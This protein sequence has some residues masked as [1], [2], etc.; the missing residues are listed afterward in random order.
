M[1]EAERCTQVAFMDAGR[2]MLKDSPDG[3]KERVPGR[4]V[5]AAVDDYHRAMPVVRALPFVKSVDLY[6][7]SLQIVI[8]KDSRSG[9]SEISSALKAAGIGVAHVRSAP[10]SMEVAFARIMAEAEA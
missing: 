10:V 3:I 5:E 8:D 7:D 6:G 2:I 9:E 4:L 1:D